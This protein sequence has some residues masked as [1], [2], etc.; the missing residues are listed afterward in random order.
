[1]NQ[2]DA[3][4]ISDIPGRIENIIP[5]HDPCNYTYFITEFYPCVINNIPIE[6]QPLICRLRSFSPRP[7]PSKM[8]FD[9]IFW[10]PF[11]LLLKNVL[12]RHIIHATTVV[13]QSAFGQYCFIGGKLYIVWEWWCVI[14]TNNIIHITITK[15]NNNLNILMN[16]I[17]HETVTWFSSLLVI[18]SCLFQ[19]KSTWVQ[20]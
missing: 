14:L 2:K 6:K 12:W 19:R 13:V 4:R 7:E 8:V 18:S 5:L 15:G 1:M 3:I 17:Y 11:M 10:L 16:N 9:W 20:Y